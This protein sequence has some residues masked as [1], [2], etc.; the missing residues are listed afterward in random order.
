MIDL[1]LMIAMHC[2]P[3]SSVYW[4]TIVLMLLKPEWY[5][6]SCRR[7]LLKTCWCWIWSCIGVE[8]SDDDGL[9][10]PGQ[11]ATAWYEKLNNRVSI[12]PL[13]MSFIGSAQ[14]VLPKK[15]AFV[16]AR[17]R[18]NAYLRDYWF[19]YWFLKIALYFATK[20]F[21]QLLVRQNFLSVLRKFKAAVD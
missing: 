14:K 18:S 5:D 20:Y 4:L 21:V 15:K 17:F 3:L 16:K 12:V 6:L 8:V 19:I 11:Y 10:T 13:A 7:C 9:M 2:L 1:R